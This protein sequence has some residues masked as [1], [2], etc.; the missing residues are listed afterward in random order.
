MRDCVLSSSLA[1]PTKFTVMTGVFRNEN[2]IVANVG[3]HV[4]I[5]III[6]PNST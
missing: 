3:L 2:Y 1:E 4:T 5:I 6:R